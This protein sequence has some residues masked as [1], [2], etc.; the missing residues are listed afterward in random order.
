MGKDGEAGGHRHRLTVTL[1]MLPCGM[2]ALPSMGRHPDGPPI[3]RKLAPVGK[4]RK[5]DAR[6]ISFQAGPK[7][8]RF[9]EL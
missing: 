3:A 4:I 6:Q 2:D 5:R 7:M 9:V 8:H 1:W